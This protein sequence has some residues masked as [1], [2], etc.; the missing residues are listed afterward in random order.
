MFCEC[1]YLSRLRPL[2]WWWLRNLVGRKRLKLKGSP[3]IDV[4]GLLFFSI[5]FEAFRRR[6]WIR[7][8]IATPVRNLWALVSARTRTG[9][10]TRMWWYNVIGGRQILLW[11]RSIRCIREEYRRKEETGQTQKLK[12]ENTNI[13]KMN[14]YI[15]VGMVCLISLNLRIIKT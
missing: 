8:N 9:R 1:T 10:S 14:K 13:K 12:I 11:T 7:F 6:I 15:Q 5:P 2:F 4:L 3:S